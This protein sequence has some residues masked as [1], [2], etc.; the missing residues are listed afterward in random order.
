MIVAIVF[1][2]I[3]QRRVAGRPNLR[4]AKLAVARRFDLTAQLRGHGLH[5]VANAE[6]RHTR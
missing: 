3:E 1:E 6:H 2:A 5:A 4:G